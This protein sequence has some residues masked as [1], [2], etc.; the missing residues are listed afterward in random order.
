MLVL[1]TVDSTNAECLRDPRLGRVVVAD[2]QTA[3]RGRLDRSWATPPGAG[4][5][6]SAVLSLPPTR[7]PDWGWLPLLAGLAVADALSAYPIEVGLK[8]PNDVLVAPAGS[9]ASDLGVWGKVCGILAQAVP[10]AP[11][12]V[13]GIG[14]N[15]NATQ[16]DLPVRTAT[17]LAIQGVVADREDL[18]ARVLTNLAVRHTAWLS[19]QTMDDLR[20]R[21]TSRCLTV[22]QQVRLHRTSGE[23]YEARA[24]GVASDGAL[25]VEDPTTGERHAHAAGDV[26]HVR[27]VM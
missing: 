23:T 6:M 4:L 27:A 11:A 21:Y 26:E 9:A 5:A 18:A 3:G 7:G 15:V 12:V 22:G 13:V 17:S 20:S 10:G 19:D 24:V 25:V 14:L 8:W 16:Q 2:E 1:P